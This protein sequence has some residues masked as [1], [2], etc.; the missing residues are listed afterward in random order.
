MAHSEQTMAK[1]KLKS[2]EVWA[3]QINVTDE[4]QILRHPVAYWLQQL[5]H[6]VAI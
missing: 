5:F 3:I 2:G 1:I 4:C 6:L